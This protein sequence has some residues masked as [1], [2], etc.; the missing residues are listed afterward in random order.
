[1]SATKKG[2][3]LIVG[4]G[5]GGMRAALDVAEA[6]LE[7]FLVES[8]PWLGGIV[9]QLGFMFPTHDCVLC[10]GTA[11]H[12]PGCTRPTISPALMDYSRHPNIHIFV[13][14]EITALE[15]EAGNFTVS[16][17]INPRHVNSDLCINCDRCAQVCPVEKPSRFQ[18]GLAMRKL[19]Y[20]SSPR[21]IP[22]AY[23]IEKTEFCETCRR[24]EK[25]C[26][27]GAINL[28]EKPCEEKIKVGAIILAMGYRLFN[29]RRYEE[30]GYGRYPNVITSMEYERLASRSGP[31]EGIVVRPSDGTTPRK[32]AWLQCI[33]SRDQEHPYCSS[34]CCMYSTKEAVLAKQRIPGVEAKIFIMDERAFNKEYNAYYLRSREL[35]KVDY[36]RSRVSSIVEDPTTRNLILRYATDDGK[37]TEE[38]FDMVV[39]SVGVEPPLGTQQVARILGIDLNQYGFC[40]TDKFGP[41]QTSRPG[42]YVC[43][44]FA[45][46]KEIAETLYEA[47]GAAAEALLLLKENIGSVNL[48][49]EFP[50]ERDVSGEEPKVGLFL[51]RC[52]GEITQAIDLETIAQKARSWPRV[53]YVQQVNLACFPEGQ[54]QIRRT[55]LEQGLNRVVVAA[56]SQRTHEPLFQKVLKRA[57]LN[58]YYLELVNIRE[59]SAWPHLYS[60]NGATRKA[61]EALRVGVA[62]AARLQAI[63]KHL[64]KP[65]KKALVLGGG[66]SGMVA[67]LTIADAGF[68]VYLVEK[69]DR[70]G[71]YLHK[72]HFTAEGKDLRRLLW[73]LT[74]RVEHHPLITIF[75]EAE[76]LRHHG[77]VGNFRSLIRTKYRDIELEHGATI[78][79]TGARIYSGREYLKGEDPRILDQLELEELIINHPERVRNLRSVVIIQCVRPMGRKYDYCSRICCTNT[80]ANAIRLK[81]LNP[82]CDVY[83]LYK[84]IITYGFRE[85]YYTRARELGTV[86]IRYTDEETPT[87][88]VLHGELRVEV[89]DQSTGELLLLNPN[90]ISLTLGILPSEDNEK[91]A[92]ILGVPLSP[93][94]FFLEAHLKMRP[95]DFIHEG[96]FLAGMAHY[97]KFIEESIA[98]AKAAAARALTYL[99]K[100]EIKIGGVIAVVEQPKCVGCLTCVRICPFQVPV[101]DPQAIGNGGIKG[102]AFIDPVKC[103]GCG[104]CT[105]ECPAKAIQLMHYTDDQIMA[106]EERALGAWLV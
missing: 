94:G 98:Q 63:Q 71:G 45:S 95:V 96:I 93:E 38:E 72:I 39:L 62:R 106:P 27:T 103:Q 51:C 58:P 76:L 46:P 70:L 26:P 32:I 83:V 65:V 41:L 89:K 29:P 57:G 16:L 82:L 102:A 25:V 75:K 104:T 80:M 66:L 99:T 90:L 9:A 33:G 4:G 43:G 91:L 81:E 86:F 47:S 3:V 88:K 56:C 59:H 40:W 10:R 42:V 37:I 20:K 28:D 55:I 74:N 67:A 97:P 34:I 31:T 2:S 60:G 68:P 101:V 15:G 30:Y 21:A 48:E 52:G 36:I 14:T 84:D 6:G 24:C 69:S 17:K 8:T 7:V 19:A 64:V 35:Y 78:V 73:E 105:A 92:R 12:G 61:A 50:P 23:M 22:D 85:E 49:E 53:A 77:H 100:S 13:N 54:E 87:V 18:M 44:S 1:M 11:E 79:A 5:V